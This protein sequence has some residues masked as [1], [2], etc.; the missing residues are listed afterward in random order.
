MIKVPIF[1]AIVSI[2]LAGSASEIFTS[3]VVITITPI[4]E[5]IIMSGITK[6][7]MYYELKEYETTDN[8]VLSSLK[9]LNINNSSK[10]KGRI[11]G[12]KNGKYVFSVEGLVYNISNLTR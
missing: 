5:T 1:L 3:D 7:N 9:T 8:I 11:T 2:F 10:L 6:D 4:K 12:I